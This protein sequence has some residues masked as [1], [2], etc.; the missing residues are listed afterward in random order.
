[1]NLRPYEDPDFDQLIRAWRAA[2][3]VAHPFLT[4]EF[5]DAEV[6]SIRDMYLPAAEAWVAEEDGVVIG[7]VALLG[8]ELG[9]LFVHPSHWKSGV[10]RAL[11]D[12]AVELRGHLSL[13]VFEANEVGRRFYESY[14]FTEDS[15]GVHAETGERVLRLT[16]DVARKRA[17]PS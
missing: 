4:P 5:L 16:Y 15:T 11:M 14:G 1:M 8:H 3:V 7:F 9:A 6:E 13:E 17:T 2:S 10:G 12:K